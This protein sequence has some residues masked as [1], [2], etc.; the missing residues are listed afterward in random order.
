MIFAPV[1]HIS[2]GGYEKNNDYIMLFLGMSLNK[3]LQRA[4][5]VPMACR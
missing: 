1:I 4:L 3:L 5:G 2:G